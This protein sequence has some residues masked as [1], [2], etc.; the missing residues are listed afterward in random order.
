MFNRLSI[1]HHQQ[2]LTVSTTD[3]LKRCLFYITN[4]EK[5]LHLQNNLI[6]FPKIYYVPKTQKDI[7]TLK[8]C[9]QTYQDF[10]LTSPKTYNEKHGN[11]N[12]GYCGQLPIASLGILFASCYD[13]SREKMLKERDFILAAM[14]GNVE[15]LKV[16]L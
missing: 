5:C 9:L 4:L 12:Y 13:N 14:V 16:S 2:P 1:F 8:I 10:F 11:S 6:K 7:P 3:K 15:R